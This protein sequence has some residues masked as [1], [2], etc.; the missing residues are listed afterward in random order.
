MAIT[1]PLTFPVLIAPKNT[2]IRM[3]NQVGVSES[4]FTFEQQV[5]QG[6]GMRWEIDVTMPPMRRAKAEY[7]I[8][9]MAKLKGRYGTFL[10]GD[11]DGRNPRGIATGTPLVN[12]ASQVGDSLITD[13]WT[14]SKTGI[15]LTGDYIQLGTGATARLYKVLDDVNS[16]GSGQA[17]FNI[18]PNL[19]SSPADN[20]AIVV[21]N[22]M[23]TWRLLSPFDWTADEISTY[24]VA[25][26][27]QEAL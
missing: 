6:Q 10:L 19:R 3:V 25:F 13:G 20:A 27:A 4:P 12:G 18:W 8:A 5:Q 7:F 15:L 9:H 22:A 11:Y 14:I 21:T 1:Y 16:N 2:K 17:T 23:T 24:G 26:S